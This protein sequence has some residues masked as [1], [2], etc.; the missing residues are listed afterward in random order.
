MKQALWP[1][2]EAEM[3][4]EGRGEPSPVLSREIADWLSPPGV[5]SRYK[6]SDAWERACSA[7]A[8]RS[9]MK[10]KPLDVRDF[11]AVPDSEERK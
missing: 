2:C 9:A 7:I 10:R 1:M 6:T 11:G 3:I 8:R 5:L 4:G